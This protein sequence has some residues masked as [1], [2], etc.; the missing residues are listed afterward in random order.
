V[1]FV[2]DLAAGGDR[3]AGP[4]ASLSIRRFRKHLWRETILAVLIAL[5]A[6]SLPWFF[7]LPL[8]LPVMLFGLVT[9]LVQAGVFTLLSCVYLSMAL[10]DHSTGMRDGARGA[11]R[12]AGGPSPPR[13]DPA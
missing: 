2:A 1:A 12:R 13:T 8:H 7:P 4:P 9:A 3:R 11:R 5:I 6:T 10:E